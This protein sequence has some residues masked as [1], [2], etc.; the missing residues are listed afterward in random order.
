MITVIFMK[1]RLIFLHVFFQSLCVWEGVSVCVLG[2]AGLQADRMWG[3]GQS[4][5]CCRVQAFMSGDTQKETSCCTYYLYL[6]L[7]PACFWVSASPL[8]LGR[9][10]LPPAVSPAFPTPPPP[11]PKKQSIKPL[12]RALTCK[13]PSHII[14]EKMPWQQWDRLNPHPPLSP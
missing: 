7:P 6:Y 5:G 4:S 11:A 1:I 14:K 8:D 3:R 13:W 2:D 10:F 9:H 12:P